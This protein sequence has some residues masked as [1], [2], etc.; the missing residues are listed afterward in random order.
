ILINGRDVTGLGPDERARLGMTLVEGGRSMFPGPT[1]RE[2]LR[3]GSYPFLRDRGRV[4]GKLDEVLDLLPQLREHLLQLAGTLSGGEQQMV[5]F[6]RAM[7]ADPRVLLID[8]LSLGLAPVVMQ[9]I[10]AAVERL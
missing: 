6:G 4:D 1:V 2:T 5:A 3:L 7:M 9:D 10:V 8:E